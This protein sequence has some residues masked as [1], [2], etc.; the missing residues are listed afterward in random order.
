MP[1]IDLDLYDALK[2]ANVPDDK[3][4]AA[5][6]ALRRTVE[7]T[8]QDLVSNTDL[9]NAVDRLES[10]T[11]AAEFRVDSKI[12]KVGHELSGDIQSLAAEIKTVD[13][14]LTAEIKAVDVKIDA[15]ERRLDG[16][17]TMLQWVVGL[18][19]AI[20]LGIFWKLLR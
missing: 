2:A 15:V 9:G 7:E 11:A 1:T 10:H 12:E 4:R 17:L 14:S 13:Q 6:A 5:A 8:R 18:N 3:A 16:K 19:V 20:S